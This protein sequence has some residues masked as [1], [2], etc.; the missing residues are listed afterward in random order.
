[1]SANGTDACRAENCVRKESWCWC[2]CWCAIVY[3][4]VVAAVAAAVYLLP[5][6]LPVA[7]T[8]CHCRRVQPNRQSVVSC[9]SSIETAFARTHYSLLKATYTVHSTAREVTG[10]SHH[11]THPPHNNASTYDTVQCTAI[12]PAASQRPAEH[13]SL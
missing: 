5:V 8:A 11:S 9:H 2:W 4:Y 12:G 6:L 10:Q 3:H 7:S 1:M 13:A